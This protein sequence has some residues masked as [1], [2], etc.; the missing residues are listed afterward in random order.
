MNRGIRNAKA[1]GHGLR[2]MWAYARHRDRCAHPPTTLWIEP[3]NRCNLRC[4]MCPVSL[5]TQGKT[6]FM[7]LD[8]YR[9][10]IG[11]VSPYATTLNLF[12]GGEPLLHRDLDT[13]IRYACEKGVVVRLNTNATLLDRTQAEKLLDSGLDH[14]I[15]SFDGYN[16]ETYEGIR[17]NARFEPTLKKILDFL[18]LKK[19]RASPHPYAV[20]QTI[21]VRQEQQTETEEQAFRARFDGLPLDAFVVREA[22]TWRGVFQGTDEFDPHAYGARYVPCPYLWS[23]M[24]IAWDGTVVP[25]C[26]DTCSDYPLGHIGEKPLLEIWNDEPI[27][28][29][30]RKL[31]AGEYRD[32]PLCSGCDLLW[33]DRAIAGFPY[34]FL[35]VSLSHPVENLL[36]YRLTNAL[37]RLIKGEL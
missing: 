31:L 18:A 37:K 13:M 22:H 34:T 9:S 32:I 10:L 16:A 23:T 28:A 20:L 4:I 25:C 17:V 24:S 11:E 3:T 29:L 2:A 27:R 6:G 12:L 5:R 30:R 19:D 36:G 14:L 1:V 7:E 26:L 8:T 35:K 21:V 33:T 15:F